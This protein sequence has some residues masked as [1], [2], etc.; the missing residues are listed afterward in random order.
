[1]DP[2]A[3]FV[4]NVASGIALLEAARAAG[5]RQFVFSSSAAVYGNPLATP[6]SET[7]PKDPVNAYGETKL[8]LERV[9][10]W[11]AQAYDW[12]VVAFRYFNA[13]GG[14]ARVGEDH[15]PETHII[16]L[17]LQ[18]ASGE[19][20]FFEVFGA[21]YPTPDGTCVRDYVHV[22][23]IAEAHLSALAISG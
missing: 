19:K 14:T 18:V 13:C 4:A 6:I 8:M 5:I 15:C 2:G 23:D 11:Y 20:E 21:D 12:T 1:A 16:P 3:F 9:L 7:H 10:E 17:L 22:S